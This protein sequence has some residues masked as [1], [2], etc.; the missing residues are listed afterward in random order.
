LFGFFC[1]LWFALTTLRNET[2]KAAYQ[3]QEMILLGG[4]AVPTILFMIVTFACP[5]VGTRTSI[6]GSISVALNILFLFSP[7]STIM[8][9]IRTKNAAS[10]SVPLCCS[11]L[12]SATF[13]CLYAAGIPDYF[14]MT[15]Q[16]VGI[17]LGTFQLSLRYWYRHSTTSALESSSTV[18]N[19]QE[20]NELNHEI[21]QDLQ[22]AKTVTESVAVELS[23]KQ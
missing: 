9:V 14:M 3:R 5:D 2:D 23:N 12:L 16:V 15:P 4:L 21:S 7:L 17:V 10:I 18:A 8:T 22:A 1:G 6:L 20:Q 11:I 19:E 13:W